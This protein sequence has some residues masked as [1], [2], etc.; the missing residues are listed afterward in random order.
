MLEKLNTLFEKTL[1]GE[2][3]IGK[4]FTETALYDET[5]DTLRNA[6]T[7]M[8]KLDNATETMEDQGPISVIGVVFNG[9]F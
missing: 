6:R 3:T 7:T 4:L 5:M 2:S 8:Q 1:N 9:L